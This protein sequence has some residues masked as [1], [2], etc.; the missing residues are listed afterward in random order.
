MVRLVLT[1][2]I[3]ATGC[4]GAQ[5]TQRDTSALGQVVEFT[6]PKLG[7]GQLGS[8]DL[9]GQV[10]LLDVWATWCVPCLASLPFYQSVADTYGGRGL[11]V[12]GVNV[13]SDASEVTRFV[14]EHGITFDVLLDP[15]GSLA[16]RLDLPAMPTLLL[17]D[18]DGHVVWKHAS[19]E[20]RD[21]TTIKEHIH[22]ALGK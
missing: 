10:V 13:D 22:A 20:A 2:M 7:G 12:V 3:L 16:A 14:A 8:R 11:R 9:H 18:R 5:K 17:L 21:K 19:F 4:A 1:A 15:E 6:L